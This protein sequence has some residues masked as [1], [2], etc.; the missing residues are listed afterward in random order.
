VETALQSQNAGDIDRI[1]EQLTRQPLDSGTKAI[2]EH[3]SDEVLMAEYHKAE[4][5]LEGL[6]SKKIH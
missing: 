4:K 5:I 2:V 3:L 1:L 6:I